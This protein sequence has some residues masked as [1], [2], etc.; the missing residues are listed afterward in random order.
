MQVLFSG[1][2]LLAMKKEP[3]GGTMRSREARSRETFLRNEFY[4]VGKA[5]IPFVY[6]QKID[7]SDLQFIGFHNT[8][9]NDLK[10]RH[11]TVHFFLDDYKFDRVYD[12]PDRY[13]PRLRQYKQLLTPDFSLYTDISISKQ[14]NAVFN[15]RWC[16]AFWQSK[17]FIVIPTMQW[18]NE[19]SFNFCFDGV[20]KG[21]IVAVSTLGSTKVKT[22]WLAGF[23][24]MCEKICPTKVVCYC[25]PFEETS[26]VA[27]II[28]VPHEG[29]I[30]RER[31]FRFVNSQKGL[32]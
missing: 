4:M 31:H 5:D 23:K 18:G 21:S 30:A 20:E 24:A 9:S 14:S 10:N 8:K 27:D 3:I 17:G 26:N 32:F 6:S 12:K 15:S 28:V 13:E 16:G 7:L 22:A 1:N 19:E 11:K 29:E 2:V 25:K